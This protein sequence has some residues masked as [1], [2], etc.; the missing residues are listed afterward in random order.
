MA[1][2]GRSPGRPGQ[3]GFHQPERPITPLLHFLSPG[4]NQMDTLI[5]FEGL[6]VP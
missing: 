4:G 1:E 5:A 6:M 2:A 3:Q